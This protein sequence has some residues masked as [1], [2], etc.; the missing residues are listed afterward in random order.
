[1]WLG[2]QLETR[3]NRCD[4]VTSGKNDRVPAK[5]SPD[6]GR[7]EITLGRKRQE[8][9]RPTQ[10]AVEENADN[11]P[12]DVLRGAVLVAVLAKSITTPDP[13]PEAVRK[14]QKGKHPENL[15]NMKGVVVRN[16]PGHFQ[17]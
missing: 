16:E 13:Q 14:V 2:P 15:V 1:M 17:C 6:H 4:H 5:F 3:K 9:R 11:I 7:L 12:V 8:K 10:K